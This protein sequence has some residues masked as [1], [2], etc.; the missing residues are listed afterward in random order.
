[1]PREQLIRWTKIDCEEDGYDEEDTIRWFAEVGRYYLR[2]ND[3]EPGFTW[4][5]LKDH[6]VIEESGAEQPFRSVDDAKDDCRRVFE[7]I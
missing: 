5:I 7:D 4:V 1:M 2:V 3:L 6:E